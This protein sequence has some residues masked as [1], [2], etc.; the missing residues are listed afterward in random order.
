MDDSQ[1]EGTRTRA[2]DEL[3][4]RTIAAHADSLLRTARRHSICAD[5]AH[6]A[7]Q[8]AIEIFMAH[9]QRLDAGRA[10]GWLHVVV[11]R[12]AQALRRSGQKLLTSA[13][14]DLDGHEAPSLPT[15]EEQ[16]LRLDMVNRSAEALKR[17]KPHE[18]RA[19]WLRA[20]GV[21]TQPNPESKRRSYCLY[22]FSGAAGQIRIRAHVR[23]L[24]EQHVRPLAT[25]RGHVPSRTHHE[26]TAGN[27]VR[28]ASC[29]G[30]LC[31]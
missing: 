1:G 15:P 8:R 27:Q 7:Y 5:D 12:E 23:R 22:V 14:I 4:L 19:L 18:L 25:V 3:I 13:E 6:D 30:T 28:S 2:A 10:A 11:K 21:P 31:E 26:G 16:L 20:Q 24:V 17:L 29:A 9:A